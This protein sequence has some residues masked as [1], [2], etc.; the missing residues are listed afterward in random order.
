[1]KIILD[2]VKEYQVQNLDLSLFY[3][4]VS[5]DEF[6]IWIVTIVLIASQV[7]CLSGKNYKLNCSS[8]NKY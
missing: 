6:S 2:Q 8:E 4:T 3:F 1:M 5:N 7:R